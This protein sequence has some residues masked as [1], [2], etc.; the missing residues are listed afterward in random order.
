MT[1]KKDILSII[2]Y[3]AALRGEIADTI[4][5]TPDDNEMLEFEKYVADYI[6]DCINANKQPTLS[7]ICAAI[8]DC[9]QDRFMCCNN[10]GEYYLCD[11]MNDETGDAYCLKCKPYYDPDFEWKLERDYKMDETLD[12]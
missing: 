10:C 4:Y 3:K 7:G 1:D 12:N 6:A 8:S 5:H 9:R 11:E 2:D